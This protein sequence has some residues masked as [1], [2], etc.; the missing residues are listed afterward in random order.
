MEIGSKIRQ[1]R[2]EAKITQEQAAEALGVSRQ[3]ISNWENEKSY[4]DIISVLKM[5]DLYNVSL[6]YLLKGESA[7]NSYVDYLDES[8]NVVKSRKK[9]SKLILIL[10]YLVIW[11]VAVIVFWCFTGEEDAMGYSLMY[12]WIILPAAT[13]VVSLLI[14]RNNFWGRYKWLGSAGFGFMYMLG[15][16]ATFSMANNAAFGRVNAPDLSMMA[17]GTVISL[18]GMGIG[19]LL[20][21]KNK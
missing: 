5:S 16:Y 13:F 17:A 20:H 2:K 3:T 15:E 11:A 18:M 9:F 10:S 4:P 21:M 12:L 14:S 1:S 8:T 7:M 6:D 19:H